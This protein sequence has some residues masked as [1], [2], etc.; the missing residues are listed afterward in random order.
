M[1][2]WLMV[3]PLAVSSKRSACASRWS[4]FHREVWL[5]YPDA[6]H[7]STKVRLFIEFLVEHLRNLHRED[8]GFPPV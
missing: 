6:R 4:L 3:L 8:L 1:A 2:C 7:V 5:V